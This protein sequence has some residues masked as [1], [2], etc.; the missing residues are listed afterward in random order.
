MKC[1]FKEKEVLFHFRPD[2]LY[3]LELDIFI[4]DLNLAFEYQGQQHF[5]P[6]PFWGGDEA[7]RKLK[8]RD[9]KKCLLCREL[10]VTLIEVNYTDPLSEDYVRFLISVQQKKK[11]Y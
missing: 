8:E 9:K 10:K 7:F 4:P 6:I 5:H 2:W 3:G 11:Q 1:I